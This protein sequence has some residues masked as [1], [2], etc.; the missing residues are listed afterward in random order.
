MLGASNADLYAAAL[1]APALSPTNAEL[2]TF[3]SGRFRL[4]VPRDEAALHQL[5]KQ[6]HAIASSAK[7]TGEQQYTQA[8][9]RE[10][11]RL[12]EA[13]PIFWSKVWPAGLAL[14]NF[15]LDDAKSLCGKGKRVL[16]LGGGIGVGAVCAALC[17]AAAVVCT[18]IEPKGLDFAL[19]SARDNGVGK[20]F[21]VA[22]WDWNE[23]PPAAVA[24]HLHGRGVGASAAAGFDCVLAG[25]T[26]YQDEHAPRLGA[27]IP[28]LVRPHG[29]AVV[30]SDSL[31]R[32]YKLEHQSVL[33]EMLLA[34]G[35]ERR[36]CK[37]VDVGADG[38]GAGVAAGKRVRLLVFCRS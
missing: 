22:R 15:L 14:G 5:I 31:E 16:E 13:E 27:L 20:C 21:S 34:R 17:G 7:Q 19:Q 38:L 3:S 32:P 1:A 24:A 35:F 8:M 4:R 11:A 29:G 37:D 26:I 30:F 33:C 10:L 12:I 6:A 2:K 28:A 36:V 9:R 25:D 18:D 23:P